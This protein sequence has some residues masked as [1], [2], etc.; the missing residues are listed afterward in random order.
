MCFMGKISLFSV[1]TI[2]LYLPT[3]LFLIFGTREYI[4]KRHQSKKK[5]AFLHLHSENQTPF[6]YLLVNSVSKDMKVWQKQSTPNGYLHIHMCVR[7][8]SSGQR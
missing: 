1:K 3:A 5:E 2:P 7:E 6:S 8:L 4:I